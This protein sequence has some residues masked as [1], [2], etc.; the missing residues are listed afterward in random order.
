MSF[1]TTLSKAKKNEY[2]IVSG[3]L[4]TAVIIGI[5]VGMNPEFVAIRNFTAGYMAASL[6]SA[7]VMFA[8]Y[9][10]I[11]YFREKKQNA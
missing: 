4:I 11:L 8:V 9:H 5:I 10:S 6:M 7:L 2:M 1:W 3:I